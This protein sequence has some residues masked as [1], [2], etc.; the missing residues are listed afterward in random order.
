MPDSQDKSGASKPLEFHFDLRTEKW[1][2]V[3]RKNNEDHVE[4]ELVG[5]IDVMLKADDFI[6]V[7]DP[8]PMVEF[9][10]LRLLIALALDIFKPHNATAWEEVWNQKYFDNE[11]VLK[12]FA[13]YPSCWDLFNDKQPFLQSADADGEDK[14]LAGLLP[15]QPSGVNPQHFSHGSEDNFAVCPA[16]AARLLTTIAPFMQAVGKG[17]FPS[18]NSTP[19]WYLL[20]QG[21]NLFET[22]WLNCPAVKGLVRFAIGDETPSWRGEPSVHKEERHE[23]SLL[24]SLTWR[25]RCIRLLH[26][27][28]RDGE[29]CVLTGSKSSR[30]VSHMK[31]SQG[32][33]TR[34]A[35][36]RDP[37]VAYDV[38]KRKATALRP[39]EGREVWRDVGALALVSKTQIT[40]KFEQPAVVKQFARFSEGRISP[41]KELKLILYG[42][43][44]R[45]DAK[46]FEWH[47][48]EL[49]LPVPLIWNENF[50]STIM[51][52]I[53]Q[54]EKVA[55]LLKQ[56][57]KL[58][59]PDNGKGNDKAFATLI[60]RAQTMFWQRLRPYYIGPS[61][62]PKKSL[63]NRLAY[64][65][66]ESDGKQ[67][68]DALKAWHGDLSRVAYLTLDETIGNLRGTINGLDTDSRAIKRQVKA[69]DFF[70][71]EMRKLLYP[72]A[73]KLKKERRK[74]ERSN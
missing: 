24:Q 1:I 39:R 8:S 13:D 42:L 33:I 29:V 14:A 12:Y 64:L 10:L 21:D 28:A 71:F 53:N 63:L 18:I 37:Y 49:K 61:V 73:A 17:N 56:A 6:A 72:T 41:D 60:T 54:A 5:L 66:P 68:Q 9:G 58:T 52:E 23:A 31:F 48:D 35:D 11:H 16:A 47:R 26:R 2:P 7:S 32:W 38:S 46:V 59:Y 55:A 45:T 20:L 74:H 30:L 27:E 57:I 25:P 43:R 34:L 36:W 40:E 65:Q 50:H 19:P 62:S 69:Q 15:S 70:R 4:V 51:Y 22:I 67:I 3:V 44:A